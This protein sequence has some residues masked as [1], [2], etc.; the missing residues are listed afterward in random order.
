MT[1]L[2][3]LNRLLSLMLSATTVAE[4]DEALRA[5]ELYLQERPEDPEVVG[6]AE[7]V[8]MVRAAHYAQG[9]SKIPVNPFTNR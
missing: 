9:A 7:Q 8:A 5:A 4:C 3:P 1:K 2:L 6:A